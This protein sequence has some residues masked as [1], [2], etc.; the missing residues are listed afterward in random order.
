V[1]DDE[2]HAQG[3]HETDQGD[4]CFLGELA[5][6]IHQND[7][8]CIE[9]DGNCDDDAG[10]CHGQRGVLHADLSQGEACN[11]LGSPCLIEQFPEDDAQRNHD[12]DAAEG[13]AK[14]GRYA[15]EDLL[16]REPCADSDYQRCEQ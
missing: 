15:G 12:A 1:A 13:A 2:A 8:R 16:H 5:R 4:S 11:L 10:E 14:A 3:G 7:K 9:V 6:Q